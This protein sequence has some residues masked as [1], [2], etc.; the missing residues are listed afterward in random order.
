MKVFLSFFFA[1]ILLS[2]SVWAQPVTID[3]LYINTPSGETDRFAQIEGDDDVISYYSGLSDR[4]GDGT[5][6]RF[7]LRVGDSFRDYG[8]FVA[9]EL[10]TL[11]GI[12]V[13][14]KNMNTDWELTLVW[15]NLAG[16]IT[17]IT[18]DS[19]K[20]EYTSGTFYLY[21]DYSPDADDGVSGSPFEYYDGTNVQMDTDSGFND[22]FLVL[23][24]TIIGG[25]AEAPLHTIIG[26]P[27]RTAS[28]LAQITYVDTNYI[29]SDSFDL[30]QL[31]TL[32]MLLGI[33]SESAE[34]DALHWI[35]GNI[36]NNYGWTDKIA[37]YG[38][39]DATLKIQAVPEPGTVLLVGSGLFLTSYLARR[40]LGRK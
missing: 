28:L 16:T 14:D 4:N 21:I 17:E 20:G 36:A 37:Q 22:G 29:A 32:N 3:D 31:V 11:W 18:T 10:R 39:G 2:S 5:I 27:A 13:D 6:D 26:N 38:E 7:D 15:E 8:N 35:D 30:G 40:K 19:I 9:T 23:Q 1:L 33:A 24:G 25:Q 34:A 12:Q